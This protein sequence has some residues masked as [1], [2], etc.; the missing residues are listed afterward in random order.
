MCGWVLLPEL[1][2]VSDR[3]CL[4]R[5]AGGPFCQLVNK[6]HRRL[7]PQ[8]GGLHLLQHSVLHQQVQT[9]GLQREKSTGIVKTDCDRK[10]ALHTYIR[11]GFR[12]LSNN[13][14]TDISYQRRRNNKAPTRYKE[15]KS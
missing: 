15:M 11:Q 8:L 13:Q 9:H 4:S 6:L 3:L 1:D 7:L 14:A 12:L 10:N 2:N 5:A